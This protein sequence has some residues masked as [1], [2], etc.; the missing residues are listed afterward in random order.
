MNSAL[1]I[2]FVIIIGAGL[3]FDRELT[4]GK[5]RRLNMTAYRVI[6]LSVFVFYAT[7]RAYSVGIDTQMY[8]IRYTRSAQYTFFQMLFHYKELR[9]GTSEIGYMC[10][11]CLVKQ[12]GFD[13]RVMLFIVGVLFISSVLW[14]I[15]EF[16]ENHIISILL[17]VCLGYMSYSMCF[18]RQFVALSFCLYSIQYIQKKKIKKF[19]IFVLVGALFHTSAVIFIPLY[20][21]SSIEL[22]KSIKRKGLIVI[23]LS[24]LFGGVLFSIVVRFARIDYARSALGGG[25]GMNLYLLVTALIALYFSDRLI[26]QSKENQLL[27]W[28]AIISAIVFPIVM[29]VAAMHRTAYYYTIGSIALIP[30]LIR[31]ISSKT[32]KLIFLAFYIWIAIYYLFNVVGGSNN[33]YL[34]FNFYWQV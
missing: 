26:A 10:L 33:G 18:M 29:R 6:M 31:S 28:M 25:M 8:Y 7:F 5:G 27:I 30:N 11:E 32:H 1:V 23:A 15:Y 13:F 21:V 4:L 17:F 34:P 24:N 22:T 12:F 19:L 16:S 14:F 3:C 9:Y 2:L 20:F